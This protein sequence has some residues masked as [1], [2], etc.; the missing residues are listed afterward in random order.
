MSLA[1]TAQVAQAER[2]G[3]SD[4]LRDGLASLARRHGFAGAIYMHVG[5]R[6]PAAGGESP[7]RSEPRLLAAT[8]GF[9]EG[10]YRRRGYLDLDPLV[11]R[12]ATAFTPFGWTLAQVAS[13]VAARPVV[14]A[15]EAWGVR[16]G[17]IAP[18]QDYAA[19][20]AFVNLFGP[21]PFLAATSEAG[22]DDP[23]LAAL[24]LGAARLHGVARETPDVRVLGL[25][26][27]EI[28]VLRLAALGRTE[29]ETAEA[30]TLSRRG[31]QFHLAR[32][33][34]KLDAPN[35]TAA[36]AR[37]VSAGVITL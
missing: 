31:V 4:D 28:Q 12:A 16:S 7:S 21:E 20:P 24:L 1:R 6:L 22:G 10:A 37:A 36:V 25:S 29:Q 17:V 33:G 34:E 18:V 5:H 9:D 14:R 2:A 15:F 13:D 26:R 23:R 19:G 8:H 11:D 35:K 32:V 3:E 30:L 27:R